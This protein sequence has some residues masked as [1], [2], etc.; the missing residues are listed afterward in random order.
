MNGDMPDIAGAW[1]A[2]NALGSRLQQQQGNLKL[3]QLRSVNEILRVLTQDEFSDPPS[4]TLS[5]FSILNL[6]FL[7]LGKCNPYSRMN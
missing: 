6:H 7:V 1:S 2:D 4:S 3:K 5:S